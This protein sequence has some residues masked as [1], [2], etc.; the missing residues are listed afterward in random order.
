MSRKYASFNYQ[1][2]GCIL[3]W[4]ICNQAGWFFD[5]SHNRLILLIY[6]QLSEKEIDSKNKKYNLAGPFC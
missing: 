2:Q 6:F 1:S 3:G 4:L 5:V